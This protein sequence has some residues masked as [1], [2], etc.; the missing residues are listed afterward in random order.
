M[1]IS[2]IHFQCHDH[3]LPQIFGAQSRDDK[4]PF[5][6]LLTVEMTK[7]VGE[8]IP[9]A[10]PLCNAKYVERRV[11]KALTAGIYVTLEIL[12]LNYPL[13]FASLLERPSH[14]NAYCLFGH[15]PTY[16]NFSKFRFLCFRLTLL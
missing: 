11:R 14:L 2:N 16:T 8:N 6:S 13:P 1:I 7:C 12:F 15:L 9:V 4:S 10:N 3:I 5:I